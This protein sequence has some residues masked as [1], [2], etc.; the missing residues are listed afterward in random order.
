MR[1]RQT[2]IPRNRATRP[3]LAAMILAAGYSSRMAQFKPLL[4]I[5][6]CTVL[7]RSIQLFL[8]AG[9]REI[10]VV[11][12]H[13]AHELQPLAQASGARCVLNPDF[14]QGM[15]SSVRVGTQA[16]TPGVD[17]CFVLPVDIPLVRASTL[18]HLASAFV[19]SGKRIIYPVFQA[20]RG[21]PPL[22][23]RS[24]LN[25]TLIQDPNGPL[26]AL[27]ARHE[28]ESLDVQVADEAIHLDMDT[29]ADYGRLCILAASRGIPSLA[30]C[31]AILSSHDA[32]SALLHH[33][34][35]VAGLAVNLASALNQCGLALDLALVQAGGLLHDIAKGKPDHA[36][37]GAA[38]LH[39]L[40]FPRVADIVASH[41]DLDFSPAELT[42]SALVYLADKL[43]RGDMPVTLEQRFQP[44]LIRFRENSEALAAANRRF[45]TAQTIASTVEARLG[46]PLELFLQT[47]QAE[48]SAITVWQAKCI[49]R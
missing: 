44:A 47:S 30:E 39:S 46:M 35:A 36:R 10:I 13:R 49:T 25:E 17:G 2:L 29:P 27:L 9:F 8:Q 26:F 12:G 48:V 15:Y 40:G 11:L 43:V 38:Y 20:E 31:E 3:K 22:I 21:H 6:D 18:Q 19:D 32:P 7:E 4:P 33:S 37:A 42:E 14:Q 16:L 34:Q 5:G 24:I 1:S 23:A 41:M 45:V 28:E